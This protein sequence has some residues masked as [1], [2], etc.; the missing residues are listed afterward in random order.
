MLSS[1]TEG[2]RR[3]RVLQVLLWTTRVRLIQ[4][5]FEKRIEL[6]AA[7]CV[8]ENPRPTIRLLLN[9]VLGSRN[10]R[11]SMF[12]LKLLQDF[13]EYPRENSPELIAFV[14][15][16]PGTS[17]AHSLLTCRIILQRC[18][19]G[20]EFEKAEEKPSS[21]SEDLELDDGCDMSMKWVDR[22]RGKA[23]CDAARLY[24]HRETTPQ[25][26]DLE[27][28]SVVRQNSA[29]GDTDA[30]YVLGLALLYGYGTSDDVAEG[31]ATLNRAAEH[32]NRN[33][34]TTLGYLYSLGQF[35][36]QDS[37]VARRYLKAAS[38]LG[39]QEAARALKWLRQRRR[40]ESGK[41]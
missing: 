26:H 31:I 13:P 4:V 30:I 21:Y 22:L 39:S 33:A 27:L 40:T 38:A 11:R 36:E 20:L 14:K 29:L 34:Q 16:V 41:A 18:F 23:F 12:L 32:G 6:L 24:L 28:V 35:V 1:L 19:A 10:P 7:I 5:V 8:Q 25:G 2:L 15:P 17:I 9:E 37:A 3:R